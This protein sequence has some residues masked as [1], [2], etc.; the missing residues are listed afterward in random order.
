MASLDL[1]LN[2]LS[3]ED[4]ENVQETLKPVAKTSPL[5][6]MDLFLGNF[7]KS[8]E[9]GKKKMDLNFIF[10]LDPGYHSQ[11]SHNL[12][13]EDDYDALV[14]TDAQQHIKWIN[15]GFS[16]MTGYSARYAMGKTPKFLQGEKT[17]QEAKSNISR[18]L[19]KKKI[20]SEIVVNYKKN[21][22]EY[23]CEITIIPL[24]NHQR[25]LAHFLAIEKEIA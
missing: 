15:K 17:R 18:Q 22:S 6:S 21:R 13:L 10:E 5:L 23:K 3:P 1:F 9:L 2:S 24:F 11:F 20:F 14:L 16:K 8:I 4:Y 25:N 19:G 7:Q 12:I